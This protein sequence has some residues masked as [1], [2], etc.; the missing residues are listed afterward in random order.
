MTEQEKKK[1]LKQAEKA[2]AAFL[3]WQEIRISHLGYVVNLVLTLTTASMGFG[4]KQIFDKPSLASNGF[5]RW[6]L[7]VLI[8][9]TAAGL[10]TNCFRLLD[11]QDTANAVRARELK[12]RQEAE[13]E[14]TDEQK[15]KAD[16][17]SFYSDRADNWGHCTWVL[18]KLQAFF[19]FVGIVLF[20]CAVW[21][22]SHPKAWNDKTMITEY[23]GLTISPT[24][25]AY[26]IEAH[27]F[28]TNTTDMDYQLSKSNIVMV[29]VPG[30]SGLRESPDVAVAQDFFVPARQKV[31]VFFRLSL[32]K[33]DDFDE[34]VTKNNQMEIKKLLAK[35]LQEVDGF[36]VFDRAAKYQIPF[37]ND[38]TK[39]LEI[40]PK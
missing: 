22:S 26:S 17:Y 32:Q 1:L 6:S 4:V 29:K 28:I 40:G 15:R 10:I 16:K 30:G 36:V 5:L 31:S 7:G 39:S 23:T 24:G 9:A 37:S 38:W 19:F 34:A 14:L 20:I 18:I 8:L 21:H 11:F 27:Y 25:N 2:H 33:R 35:E 13:E 12:K 3:R